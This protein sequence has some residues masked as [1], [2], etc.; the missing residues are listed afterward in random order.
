MTEIKTKDYSIPIKELS[1]GAGALKILPG[2]S[3]PDTAP[4]KGEYL[5]VRLFGQG[6]REGDSFRQPSLSYDGLRRMF[7]GAPVKSCSAKDAAFG[8]RGETGRFLP[9]EYVINELYRADFSLSK[10]AQEQPEAMLAVSS[11]ARSV[12][13]ALGQLAEGKRYCFRQLT[14]EQILSGLDPAD[15]RGEQVNAGLLMTDSGKL[16]F[17]IGQLGWNDITEPC[18]VDFEEGGA[19]I[20][21]SGLTY[22]RTRHNVLFTG[23]LGGRLDACP[24]RGTESV[25]IRLPGG[26]LLRFNLD[27]SDFLNDSK[28]YY[29]FA[30]DGDECGDPTPMDG[31]IYNTRAPLYFGSGA[32]Y[33]S[34]IIL[35]DRSVHVSMQIK[36]LAHGME[37]PDSETDVFDI[38]IE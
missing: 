15:A 4:P 11:G 22:S 24:G 36:M 27:S 23:P 10:A 33:P 29:K 25:R 26:S 32:D 19:L 28:M 13:I 14:S 18:F 16:I 34:G 30:F 2:A 3:D 31:F 1:L 9:L 17:A 5:S 35:P 12:R 38:E 21:L 7:E 6:V 8:Y 20:S 37:F